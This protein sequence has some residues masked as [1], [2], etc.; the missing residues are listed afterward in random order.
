[1][2]YSNQPFPTPASASVFSSIVDQWS[3]KDKC[4]QLDFSWGGLNTAEHRHLHN[5]KISLKVI[6]RVYPWGQ[7][8]S[9]LLVRSQ[10]HCSCLKKERKKEKP[11]KKCIKV[12]YRIRFP[13]ELN[14]PKRTF[15]FLFFFFLNFIYFFIR[16]T[17]REAETE[18]EGE[19]GSL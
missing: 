15:S 13:L 8:Q 19:T 10:T 2:G 1:M 16:G 18:A 9:L 4:K 6:V 17:Q 11:L 7:K 3:S 12:S 5:F 14:I